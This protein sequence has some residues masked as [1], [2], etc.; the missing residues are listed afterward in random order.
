M[1][2]DPRTV[3][4]TALQQ[5]NT[6]EQKKD[7]DLKSIKEMSREFETMLIMEMYKTMRKAIPKSELFEQSIATEMF[8][9]MFDMEVARAT[10]A[11]NGL[12]IADAMYRQMAELADKSSTG[13]K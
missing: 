8:Q 4:S 10:A 7:N 2:I 6:A 3:I 9:E 5:S 13:S 12:G 1:N 11:G